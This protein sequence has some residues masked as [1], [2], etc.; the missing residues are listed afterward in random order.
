MKVED[1]TYTFPAPEQL[2]HLWSVG[3]RN[4]LLEALFTEMGSMYKHL[5]L[6]EQRA[7]AK[8]PAYVTM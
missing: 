3:A 2:R 5:P 7:H 8:Y 6:A 1:I 4:G